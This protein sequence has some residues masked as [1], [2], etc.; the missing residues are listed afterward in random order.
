MKEIDALQEQVSLEPLPAASR[1]TA[2]P[3]SDPTFPSQRCR[4][5]AVRGRGGGRERLQNTAEGIVIAR[6]GLRA[7]SRPSR[8]LKVSN[9]VGVRAYL[10]DHSPIIQGIQ[11][12]APGK[13]RRAKLYY[14]RT[15]SSKAVRQGRPEQDRGREYVKAITS[16]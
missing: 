11:S 7:S 5:C 2:T 3:M 6:R 15:L 10:P 8:F 1:A 12:R 16:R 14:L 13:V 9:G 4:Q